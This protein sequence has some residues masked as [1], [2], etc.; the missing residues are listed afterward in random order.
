MAEC[1]SPGSLFFFR[2]RV[3]PSAT[4]PK[5]SFVAPKPTP[6]LESSFK[7]QDHFWLHSLSHLFSAKA[8]G[9]QELPDG[10]EEAPDPCAGNME[11]NEWT[12]CSNCS[13]CKMKAR[14]N[15]STQTVSGSQAPQ[16]QRPPLSRPSSDS[17]SKSSSLRV[18]H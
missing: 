17:H 11:V 13:N 9:Y 1:T 6:V 7:D 5:S 14:R 4:V 15:P 2:S 3:A 12:M 8:T 10:P 18:R 16:S